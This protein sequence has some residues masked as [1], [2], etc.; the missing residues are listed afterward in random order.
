MQ[1]IVG[2]VGPRIVFVE[3]SP[4][5][6]LSGTRNRSRGPGRVGVRCALGSVIR[7]RCHLAWWHSGPGSSQRADPGSQRAD[8]GYL[9]PTPTA[10][11]HRSGK[12]SEATMNRNSRPLSE[13]VA[14]RVNDKGGG[15]LNPPCVEWL[16]GWPIGW[17]ELRALA[18]DR[19]QQWLSSHGKSSVR[20]LSDG[21]T[22][23]EQTGMT[24]HAPPMG[25][26]R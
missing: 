11:D 5:L 10:R 2:E 24:E 23:P 12:A 8:P 16:M 19:F 18:M 15:S 17:T 14:M 1:R 26:E 4:L 20:C 3:N 25:G 9:L 7:C 13:V 6:H 22:E 21:K